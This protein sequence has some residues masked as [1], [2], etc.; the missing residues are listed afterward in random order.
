MRPWV[1]SGRSTSAPAIGPRLRA[2]AAR[3]EPI[4]Y[5]LLGLAAR[6]CVGAM[7]WRSGQ[8]KI[9]GWRLSENAVYL[10][11][12]EYRLPLIDPWLAAA[13]AAFIENVFSILLIV[14]LASRLAASGLLCTTLVIELFVYPD[15]WALHGT[16]AVCLGLVV[17]RGAGVASVDHWLA[18]CF[19][20]R[21]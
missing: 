9:V 10:F 18:R 15:A 21:S 3:C 8:T 19:S 16:W 4:A 11:Q 20:R 5:D 12:T 7:F 2:A 1:T 17:V 14:G 6:L 13:L